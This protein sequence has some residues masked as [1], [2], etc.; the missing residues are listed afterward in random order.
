MVL[1]SCLH[2]SGNST[3]NFHAILKSSY[4]HTNK[5]LLHSK[6][7]GLHVSLLYSDW[8]HCVFCSAAFSYQ[9]LFNL[10]LTFDNCQT[11]VICSSTSR[12][13]SCSVGF[14]FTSS[15][16]ELAAVAFNKSLNVQFDLLLDRSTEYY[17][18]ANVTVDGTA[19]QLR[20]NFSTGICMLWYD[21]TTSPLPSSP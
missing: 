17:V 2:R 8:L 19:F 5:Q 20:R 18:Q 15:N 9:S 10:T 21:F 13:G 12:A 16:Q 4:F 14:S 11:S 3:F 1:D 6:F 7:N